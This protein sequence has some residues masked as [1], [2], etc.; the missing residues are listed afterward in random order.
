MTEA[1]PERGDRRLNRPQFAVSL[2]IAVRT[3]SPGFFI[4]QNQLASLPPS[5]AA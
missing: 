2:G 1:S 3:E 5:V 4:S